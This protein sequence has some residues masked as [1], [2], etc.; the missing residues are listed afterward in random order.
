MAVVG[1]VIND[2]K[3]ADWMQVFADLEQGIVD[4]EAPNDVWLHLL[5]RER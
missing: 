4:D 1:K 2:L 3:K 5:E